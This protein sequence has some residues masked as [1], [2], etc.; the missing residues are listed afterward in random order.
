MEKAVQLLLE[1]DKET[2]NTRPSDPFRCQVHKG[3][4]QSWFISSKES[5]MYDVHLPGENRTF[6][7]D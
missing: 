3:L 4:A 5:D 2:H 6:Q 7:S 1:F